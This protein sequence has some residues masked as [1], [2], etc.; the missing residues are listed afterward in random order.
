VAVAADAPEPATTDLG[1]L[2]RQLIARVLAECSG[3]KS[4]AAA[5]LG[6]SR[7]QLYVR[8]RKYRLT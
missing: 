4:M 2:E 3:N 6:L 1:V 7:T 8:L 5:R